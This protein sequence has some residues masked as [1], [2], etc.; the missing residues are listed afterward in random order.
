MAA[1]PIGVKF[2]KKSVTALPESKDA[3]NEAVTAASRP[4]SA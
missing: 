3:R 1:T 2:K 4:F